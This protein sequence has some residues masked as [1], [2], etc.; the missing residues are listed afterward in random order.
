MEF[1][2]SFLCSVNVGSNPVNVNKEFILRRLNETY[3]NTCIHRLLVKSV[4]VK[5]IG[6]ARITDSDQ[7]ANC[8]VDVQVVAR[9]YKFSPGDIVHDC[10]VKEIMSNEGIMLEDADS[11]RINMPRSLRS[12]VPKSVLAQIS[13]GIK[14]PVIIFSS[15]NPIGSERSSALGVPFSIR[16]PNLVK[17]R[18][19]QALDERQV[20][21]AEKLFHVLE[22][23][24]AKVGEV[25]KKLF[26]ISDPREVLKI[27]KKMEENFYPYKKMRAE[28]GNAR[29]D[30][31]TMREVKDGSVV[32][33][34][35]DFAN[36]DV[37]KRVLIGN[38][39]KGDEELEMS[40]YSFILEVAKKRIRHLDLM[41]R[42]V[43]PAYFTKG[44]KSDP[45]LPYWKSVFASKER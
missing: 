25:I 10:T 1:S 9:G 13:L 38:E 23:Q 28:D 35:T 22:L 32:F 34:L 24:E 2:K 30:F 17:A 27:R 29:F 11:I 16:P 31:E 43:N 36:G 7:T 41:S 45:S 4:E 44:K 40:A 42:V 33:E 6:V 5:K 8:V 14:I 39:S 21:M 20:K 18:I 15:T 19:T 3:K 37:E 12:K 26:S